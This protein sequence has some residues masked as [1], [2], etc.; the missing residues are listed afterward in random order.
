[1]GGSAAVHTGDIPYWFYSLDSV[2]YQVLGDEENAY[3]VSNEMSS[4][5]AAFMATGDPSTESLKWLP[6]TADASN[7]MVFDVNSELRSGDFDAEILGIINNLP[8]K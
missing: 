5:L 2:K 3:K 6:D 7:T 8:K 4:A 1:M